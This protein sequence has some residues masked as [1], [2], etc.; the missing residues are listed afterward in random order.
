MYKCPLDE[1]SLAAK[2]REILGR[3]NVPPKQIER[4]I[5]CYQ[6]TDRGYHGATHPV[7]MLVAL[8]DMPIPDRRLV[9]R[10]EYLV[11]FHDAFYEVGRSKGTNEKTSA[12]WGVEA[13]ESSNSGEILCLSELMMEGCMA[14]ID[15]TLEGVGES[16]RPAVSLLLDLD[17]WS[18]GSDIE[19]FNE[20]TE[21]VWHEHKKIKNRR[22]FDA[23]MVKWAEAF[24]KR[25]KIYLTR[26]AA[27][28][29]GQARINLARLANKPVLY[30]V[31]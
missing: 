17:L 28:R 16:F 5:M 11:L 27:H 25:D 4:L 8:N 15:H 31:K 24:L 7:Q 19:V 18:L 10:V 21:G 26:Y 1:M 29:E 9:E 3:I 22:K 6:D 23:D 14:T 13:I 30:S 2:A 20:N 12:Q